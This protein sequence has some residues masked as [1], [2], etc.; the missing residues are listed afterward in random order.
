MLY[1]DVVKYNRNCI[2]VRF[3]TVIENVFKIHDVTMN[4]C[5]IVHV[6]PLMHYKAG[7]RVRLLK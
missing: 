5:K 7:I 2:C 1:I 6:V 3:H 4:S